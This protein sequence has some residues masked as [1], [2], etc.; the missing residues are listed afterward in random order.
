MSSLDRILRANEKVLW[1]GKPA[2]KAFILPALGGIPFGLLFLTVFFLWLAR[3]PLMLNPPFPIPL[4]LM[5]A[6]WGFGLIVVPPIWQ[7]KKYPNTEY[8]ITDE[9][10]II[11]T[12]V[13]RQKMWFAY[14]S[15]IE[16]VGVKVGLVD[17]LFGTGTVYPITPSYPFAPGERVLR[18]YTDGSPGRVHKLYN[19]ATGNYEEFSEWQIWTK[20]TF[21]PCLSALKE[22]AEVQKLLQKA[23]ENARQPNG[24]TASLGLDSIP[25]PTNAKILKA[26]SSQV[27]F[28]KKRKIAMVLGVSLLLT[29][30]IVFA[31]GYITHYAPYVSY[32][33]GYTY[34]DYISIFGYTF[35]FV[36]FLPCSLVCFF[37]E[38]D[39]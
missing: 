15:E 8:V 36:G 31:Y 11:K 34:I 4:A 14:L 18:W 1:C 32:D 12:W 5:L 33:D 6:G 28:P 22:P 30:V 29:G 16:K 23:I 10:L 35:V 24:Q 38:T 17:K 21:R 39:Q 3:I 20:T 25:S 27:R 7:L 13:L 2:R 9:R 26:I 19:P 37:R